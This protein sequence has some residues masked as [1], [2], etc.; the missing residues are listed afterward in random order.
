MPGVLTN[1]FVDIP[2]A[3]H[4]F[5]AG[6][7]TSSPVNLKHARKRGTGAK[8]SSSTL[9]SLIKHLLQPPRG[10]EFWQAG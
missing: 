2:R 8:V 4:V 6:T 3:C 1:I 7:I 10:P 5:L 9:K